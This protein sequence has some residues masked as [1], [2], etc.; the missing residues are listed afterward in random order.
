MDP[1]GGA[2]GDPLGHRLIGEDLALPA[3]D[4]AEQPDP[5]ADLLAAVAS[6]IFYVLPGQTGEG[7]EVATR[8]LVQHPVIPLGIDTPRLGRAHPVREPAGADERDA[9]T[10]GSRADEVTHEGADLA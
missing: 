9:L 7:I 8:D 4:R 5:V 1:D 10:A 6:M 2:A 3:G